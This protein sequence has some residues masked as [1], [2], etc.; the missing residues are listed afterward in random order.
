MMRGRRGRSGPSALLAD[1]Q[2]LS[3]AMLRQLF[4]GQC[5]VLALHLA[6]MPAWL[7]AIALLTA[8]YR[9]LQLRGRLG[10]AGVVVRLA[11]IA[12]LSGGLWLHYGTLGQM[13]AMI[14]LLLGVYLLKL[15]ETHT[16]RD[17]RVVVAGGRRRARRLPGGHH[18]ALRPGA[19]SLHPLS[20]AADL[21]QPGR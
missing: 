9:T 12:A 19:L 17:G 2:A 13:E 6:W 5:L 4:L 18:G 1:G 14:G 7:A 21:R 8:G 20:A 10:R 3:G 15:L 11:G 16:R